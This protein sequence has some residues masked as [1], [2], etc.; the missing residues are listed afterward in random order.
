MVFCFFK[1]NDKQKECDTDT[2]KAEVPVDCQIKSRL[3][4][5]NIKCFNEIKGTCDDEITFNFYFFSKSCLVCVE[6]CLELIN[7]PER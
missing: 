2:K 4:E 5:V 7:N 3:G 6:N 1:S